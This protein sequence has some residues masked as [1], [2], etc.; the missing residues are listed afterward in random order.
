[1]LRDILQSRRSIRKFKECAVEK[2]QQDFLL[3]AALLSPS[4]RAIRPWEIIM[5]ESPLLLERLSRAKKHGSSFLKNAPLAAVVLGIPSE[6]DV[7]IE[8]T[9]I[10]SSNILLAA[11]NLGLGA[12]WIQIRLRESEDGG[13]SEDFV[14]ETLKIPDTR[15]VEALIALGYPDEQKT[16]SSLEELQW[17]KVFYNWYPH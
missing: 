11:E 12:C 2:E 10:V 15:S 4:S 5:V 9:A 7:W 14:R 8:D 1:M 17:Q 6:S 13:S 16:R 3:Q